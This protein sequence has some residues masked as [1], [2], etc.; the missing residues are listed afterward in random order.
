MRPR[1]PTALACPRLWAAA[2]VRGRSLALSLILLAPACAAAWAAEPGLG[3]AAQ[4][5]T[6]ADAVLQHA[7]EAARAIRDARARLTVEAIDAQGRRTR[8]TVL[9]AFLRRP[10]LARLEV[11]EPAALAGQVY[12]LDGEAGEMR[13]YLPVTNQI[14]VQPLGAGTSGSSAHDLPLAPERLVETFAGTARPPSFR[15]AG[16][17]QEGGSTLYVLEAPL[18]SPPAGREPSAAGLPGLRQL[19]G[20][21]M[22]A[23]QGGSVRVWIDGASWLPTRFVFYDP[24]GRQRAT[25]VLTDVRVNGGLRADALRHLPDD[26]EVVEG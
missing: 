8:S 20:S 23:A 7:A 16:T 19:L 10:A 13:V 12:V 3:A 11:V 9:A 1:R 15:L 18:P 5:P 14:V 2:L 21:G 24:S 6:T 4:T 17:Q 22:E 25:V 26:A